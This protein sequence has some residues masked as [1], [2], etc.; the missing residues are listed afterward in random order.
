MSKKYSRREVLKS[1]AAVTATAA[2]L[3][4][5]SV[6]RAQ[7][8]VFAKPIVAALNAPTGNP[9]NLSIARIPEIMKEKFGLDANVQIFPP[10]A[11]GND[12]NVLES[13]QNG[14]VDISSNTTAQFS[15][16]DGSF[17]FADLPYAIPDWDTGLRLFKSDL[18]KE[19]SE[20]FEAAVPTLKVLPPVGAGGFRLLWN[21]ERQLKTPADV[22]G[23][24]FRATRSPIGQALFRAWNGNPT[25]IPFFETQEAIKNGVVDGFHVQP[26]WTYV[27][28]FQEVLKHATRVDATFS[29]Q[30]QVMNKNTWNAMPPKFQ[31]AFWESAVLAADEANELDRK[32]EADFA[33]KLVDAGMVIYT[34]TPE[35]KAQWQSAGEALWDEIGKDIDKSVIEKLLALRHA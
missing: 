17:N 35:E 13:V 33:Q 30:F 27:F 9:T 2:T 21:D 29:I 18:W 5:P 22:T 28:K 6:L 14:F 15:V 23:L 32:L 11:L 19:Q 26:I 12:I 34:P 31:E 3:G 8:V 24:K 25:P 10:N 7:D 20:K 16:F 1:T 4:L